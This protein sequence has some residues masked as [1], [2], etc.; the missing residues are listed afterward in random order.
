VYV[1][2]LTVLLL[3]PLLNAMAFTVLVALIVIGPP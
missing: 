3:S 1:A 2:V